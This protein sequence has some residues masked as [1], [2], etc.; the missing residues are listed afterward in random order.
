MKPINIIVTGSKGRMG[1]TIVGLANQDSGLKVVGQVDMGDD[2]HA[3]IDSADVVIDFSFHS[4]TLAMAQAAA[5]HKK[6]IVIG[7]TGHSAN[8]K[9]QISNLKSQV[10]MV[11]AANYSVGV[12]LLFALTRRAAEVLGSSYDQEVV[13][14]HHRLKK[15]APSGT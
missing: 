2:I 3:V 12:N 15:D 10:P 14:M 4:A 13:E 9:S 5:K 11:W 7:T 8:E 6:A 1:Q